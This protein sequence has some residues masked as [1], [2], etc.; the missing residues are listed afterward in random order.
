MVSWSKAMCVGAMGKDTD[1]ITTLKSAEDFPLWSK[2]IKHYFHYQEIWDVVEGTK[3]LEDIDIAQIEERK[4]W[5]K[6]DGQASTTILST[7]DPSVKRHILSC[8][9]ASEMYTKLKSIY[10]Q[11][12]AQQKCVLLRSFYNYKYNPSKDAQENI[13]I[14]EHIQYRLNALKQPIDDTMV[15][16]KILDT[17]PKEWDHINSAW[18]ATE[19]NKR[20][21]SNLTSRLAKAAGKSGH[22]GPEEE[23][24]T[25]CYRAEASRYKPKKKKT[26]KTRHIPHA[27]YV[28]KQ[29]TQKMLVIL[30][31]ET[32][33]TTQKNHNRKRG[34]G[35][36]HKVAPQNQMNKKS[37]K[38]QNMII[39][40]TRDH[41]LLKR[42]EK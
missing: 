1:H 11:D 37:I 14:I 33:S 27:K 10:E 13:A 12:T 5:K 17:I 15:C 42:G 35:Q 40:V 32:N 38:N 36:S 22:E 23:K 20:T 6:S 39:K 2:E 30:N 41:T 34:L 25:V 9:T 18:E 16:E 31:P 19:A 21:L 26:K 24:K 3:V 29:I 28:Q 8:E 7:I 4:R